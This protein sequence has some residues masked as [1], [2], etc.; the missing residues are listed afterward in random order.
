VRWQAIAERHFAPSEREGLAALPESF[1]RRAFF[2]LW[3]RKEAVMKAVG[4]GLGLGVG[5]VVA[6]HTRGP[7]TIEAP[8]DRG[9]PHMA[10]WRLVDIPCGRTYVGTVAVEDGPCTCR[11]WRFQGR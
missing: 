3:T 11:L 4:R 6:P 5:T 7:H 2:R 8:V 10:R 1:R 9:S